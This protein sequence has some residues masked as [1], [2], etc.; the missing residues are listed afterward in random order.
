MLPLFA[1][2]QHQAL[3]AAHWQLQNNE[4]IFAFLD[5]IYMVTSP[6]MVGS[7][8]CDSPGGVAS[9]R[10]RQDPRWKNEGV[11]SGRLET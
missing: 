2:G 3:E 11:E 1:V 7:R 10:V 8:V 5:D 6:E 9:S 4:S